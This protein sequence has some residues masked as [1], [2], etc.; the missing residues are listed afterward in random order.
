VALPKAWEYQ[1]LHALGAP[2]TKE[3]LRFLRAWQIAEG[4]GTANSANYN[5]LNT[6][7]PAMGAG[8]INSVGV[9]SY[10]SPVQGITATARTLVNGHYDQIVSMLRSGKANASQLA[11]AVAHSPWGTGS[12]V[13]RVLGSGPVGVPSAP[14]GQPGVTAPSPLA[15]ALQ[16]QP[17]H[18]VSPKPVDVTPI[19]TQTIG[20]EA[21][22]WDPLDAL[23]QAT[24]QILS[25]WEQP[26]KVVSSSL[27][28]PGAPGTPTAAP[29]DLRGHPVGQTIRLGP[30]GGWD[31]SQRP[32]MTLAGIGEKYG[33]QITSTK[34][35]TKMSASGLVS[36]HWIGSKNAYAVDLG[37]STPEMDKAAVAIAH[38]LG[39]NYNGHSELVATKVVGGL[40]YQILY[41]THVGGNHFNHIHIGVR[42]L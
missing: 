2:A 15:Q 27:A 19:L 26:S 20:R 30:G 29:V 3:N 33:L 34:R 41:R 18:L 32:A 4:G 1:L 31:G 37:G 9:R 42:R 10:R 22:G 28:A 5:P 40:R 6:T 13:L 35:D 36:D 38:R 39:I 21:Q 14:H 25:A 11:T 16:P 8:T 7:E 12:G 23:K 24:P 17:M